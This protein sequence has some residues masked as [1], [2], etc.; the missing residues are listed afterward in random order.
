MIGFKV[1]K[2]ENQARTGTLFVRGRQINT[3]AF[4]PVATRGALKGMS[5]NDAAFLGAEM[6]MVNTF[7]FYCRE[8]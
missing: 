7:H 1:E 3:P 5:F 4:V 8:E 6:F 2:K